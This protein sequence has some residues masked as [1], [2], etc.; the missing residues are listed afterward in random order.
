MN[1]LIQGSVYQSFGDK[2]KRFND[3]H[4]I[5]YTGN[6]FIKRDMR[7]F[8][9]IIYHNFD[10]L[11]SNPK[12][13]HTRDEIKRILISRK[14]IIIIAT[15]NGLIVGYILAE[16]TSVE[17]YRLLLHI[18]YLYTSP[19]YRGRGIA[20]QLIMSLQNYSQK[21][22]ITTISLT[23]DTYNKKLE[24][25]YLLNNFMYDSKLRSYQRHDMMVK[26]I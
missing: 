9:E 18:Y 3:V 11:N 1:K 15:L 17:N 10:E 21:R 4:V 8:I 22:N 5:V 16:T 12:L 26:H 20:S 25:F 13:N 6:D 19:N 2:T 23:F 24:K 7:K 14:S